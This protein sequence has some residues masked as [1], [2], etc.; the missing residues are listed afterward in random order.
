MSHGCCG[1]LVFG[2]VITSKWLGWPRRS[3]IISFPIV[4]I[5]RASG[6]SVG[7]TSRASEA[8]PLII[9]TGQPRERGGPAHHHH[10]P[11]DFHS[12]PLRCCSSS[13]LP[14]QRLLYARQ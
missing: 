10:I 11:H 4:S 9:I 7:H 8:A 5:S 1:V 3:G 6:A 13:L 12:R 2:W 14:A